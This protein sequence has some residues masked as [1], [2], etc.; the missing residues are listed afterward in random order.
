MG[1][2]IPYYSHND[3][4]VPGPFS[5]GL[6][7]PFVKFHI[8]PIAFSKADILYGNTMETFEFRP[9]SLP[10]DSEITLS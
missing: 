10:Y 9:I 5:M 4:G 1:A 8:I 7:W 2:I 6:L 3:P